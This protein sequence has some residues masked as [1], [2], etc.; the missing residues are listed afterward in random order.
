VTEQWHLNPNAITSIFPLQLKI[1]DLYSQ[2]S[3]KTDPN[4]SEIWSKLTQPWPRSDQTSYQISSKSVI[5]FEVILKVTLEVFPAIMHILM[6][7]IGYLLFTGQLPLRNPSKP[8]LC[9]HEVS[10]CRIKNV[11]S[12]RRRPGLVSLFCN[13]PTFRCHQKFYWAWILKFSDPIRSQT[14]KSDRNRTKFGLKS[15]QNRSKFLKNFKKWYYF[16]SFLVRMLSDNF[17]SIMHNLTFL[18]KISLIFWSDF[19]LKFDHFWFFTFSRK[20]WG[21]IFR[22]IMHIIAFYA[23]NT[24]FFWSK[25]FSKTSKNDQKWR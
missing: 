7:S 19:W 14:T 25:I 12:D 9:A 15:D 22:S 13:L 20:S 10:F 24:S 1:S 3:I 21:V 23:K 17:E 5:I 2:L 4:S 16:S 8:H 11:V 6:I 18:P